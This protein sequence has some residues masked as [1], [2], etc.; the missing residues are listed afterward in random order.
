M[1]LFWSLL[2]FFFFA[3]WLA[4]KGV[5]QGKRKSYNKTRS[6]SKPS[7]RPDNDPDTEKIYKDLTGVDINLQKQIWDER[8]RGY[9]GEFL[10]FKE[11][12]K[13]I[14]GYSKFLMNVQIP[15]ANGK[16][17]EID[18]LMFDETGIYVFEIKHYKGHIYGKASEN[19]WTQYFRTAPNQTFLNP[20]KQNAYHVSAL[21]TL[22]PHVEISSV[23]VFTNNEC[24][25]K[26][27]NDAPNVKICYLANLNY[28]VSQLRSNM[29]EKATIQY[30][31]EQIDE[32]PYAPDVDAKVKVDGKVMTMYQ[33]LD[34]LSAEYKVSVKK[35]KAE[36]M[37]VA[38]KKMIRVIGGALAVTLAAVG[39][40][41]Y[42]F[43]Q[44]VMAEEALDEFA[45]RFEHVEDLHTD[46]M[47][48]SNNLVSVENLVLKESDEVL[49]AVEISCTLIGHGSEYGV[50]IGEKATILVQLKDKTV[51]AYD[52][53]NEK[54]PYRNSD[55]RLGEKWHPK[56][57]MGL[58]V[59]SG[60]SVDDI[61]YIK[62]SNLGIVTTI[63]YSPKVIAE[64]YEIQ[65]F[66]YGTTP[67]SQ[68]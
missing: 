4:K 60:L 22:F 8:G 49:N 19:N 2:I 37:A 6:G 26:V 38:K 23:V 42:S 52:L 25:L 31:P 54:Y 18:L 21:K 16:T 63:N 13:T 24:T 47:V 34:L 46:S 9:Y 55:V 29:K 1:E 64:G 57:N 11:L 65:L 17:T 12:Y 44:K 53:W 59:L 43:G 61:E 36:A 56:A 14:P 48:F 3:K 50:A 10:V 27:E 67:I 5:F 28:I 62:L 41:V 33:Y 68:E 20:V 58:H 35:N 45:H 40:C 15:T 7:Y 30:T 51:K 39:A 32:M 66:D